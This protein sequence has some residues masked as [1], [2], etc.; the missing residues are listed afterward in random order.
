MLSKIH[1]WQMQEMNS[2]D[3]TEGTGLEAMEAEDEDLAM[4]SRVGAV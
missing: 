4:R 1:G 3:C 2:D